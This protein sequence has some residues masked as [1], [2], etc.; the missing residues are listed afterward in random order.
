[1]ALPDGCVTFRRGRLQGR[2]ARRRH[3]RKS[4]SELAAFVRAFAFC[5]DCSAEHF[6]QPA[7][8]VQADAQSTGSALQRKVCLSKELKE[9]PR[10][11]HFLVDPDTVISHSKD[12]MF[13]RGMHAINVDLAAV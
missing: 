9:S 4:N 5:F 3:K 11:Q 2:H 7:H 10:F 8:E 12:G 6:N 13:S 1:M